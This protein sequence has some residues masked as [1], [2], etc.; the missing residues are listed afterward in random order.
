[1]T[2]YKTLSEI[3]PRCEPH[4]HDN[5]LD[6]ITRFHSQIAKAI[7]GNAKPKARRWCS[8]T[9]RWKRNWAAPTATPNTEPKHNLLGK[10]GGNARLRVYQADPYQDEAARK[11][12]VQKD[13]QCL[14]RRGAHADPRQRAGGE[15][16]VRLRR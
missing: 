9:G 3:L 1:M 7:T 8:A 6:N 12:R 15:G 16:S 11:G 2:D 14:S 13:P 4:P 5:R 10:S